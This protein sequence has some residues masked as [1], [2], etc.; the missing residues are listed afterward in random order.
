MGNSFQRYAHQNMET[1]STALKNVYQSLGQRL[2]KYPESRC[3]SIQHCID[4]VKEKNS[5]FI[6]VIKINTFH[7]NEVRYFISA[8]IIFQ[9]QIYSPS[10]QLRI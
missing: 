8:V 3:L 5:V 4:F 7:S 1:S 10:I 6:R 9:Y 2:D